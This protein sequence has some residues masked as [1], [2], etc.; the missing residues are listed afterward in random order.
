MRDAD[1]SSSDFGREPGCA[2]ALDAV[3]RERPRPEPVGQHQAPTVSG[4][5]AFLLAGQLI[6]VS[7]AR[8]RSF[9]PE[10]AASPSVIDGALLERRR[11]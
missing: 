3:R 2:G 5:A 8:G 10:G 7:L 4:S 11:R 6:L 9:A 1:D